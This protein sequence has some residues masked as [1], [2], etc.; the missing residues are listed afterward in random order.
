MNARPNQTTKTIL[1]KNVD[2]TI[3]NKCNIILSIKMQPHAYES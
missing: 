1:R 2:P 3:N